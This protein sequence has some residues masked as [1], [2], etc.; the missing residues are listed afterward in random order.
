MERLLFLP[1]VGPVFLKGPI[2]N[3]QAPIAES[4]VSRLV[5]SFQSAKKKRIASAEQFA[6]L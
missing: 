5:K 6:L 2:K 3:I 1:R 4:V